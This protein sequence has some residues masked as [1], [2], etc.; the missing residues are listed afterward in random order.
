[1]E[2]QTTKMW[3]QKAKM[4]MTMTTLMQTANWTLMEILTWPR[5]MT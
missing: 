2:R 3:M 5:R 4:R 1:M